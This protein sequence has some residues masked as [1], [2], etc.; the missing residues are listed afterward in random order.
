MALKMDLTVCVDATGGSL[1]SEFATEFRSL[2]LLV[3]L[4]DLL[5][6]TNPLSLCIGAVGAG[7]PL[8]I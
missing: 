3:L 5:Q 8:F 4:T 6:V 2:L 7:T 1:L